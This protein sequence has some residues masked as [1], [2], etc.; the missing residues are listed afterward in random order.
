[1]ESGPLVPATN[2]IVREMQPAAAAELG[3]PIGPR[4]YPELVSQE[5]AL[6]EYVRVLVKRKWTVLACL[7]T[8]FSVVAIASLKMTPVYEAS[9]SIEINKPDS[10]LVNFSNSPTFNVEYDE[11][12][13]LETE[14]MILQ[15]DLLALQVVK[16]LA[17]DRRPEF[18][19]K[20]PTLPSSLD[21]APDA[22]Q[23][24]T[25]RT[26]SLLSSF[27]G[28]LAVALVPNS[29]IIEVHYRS[30]NKEL[31]ATVVNTVMST[32]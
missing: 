32:Y 1:M 9:G 16:E 7:F 8:I 15:S 19:G 18:G 11:P 12:S 23:A 26:S 22:L 13:K 17:L 20:T 24:D 25:G 28:N 29:H 27:R 14:V 6:G 10:G 31:A 30:P 4:I 3:R 5:S 21:L 2:P